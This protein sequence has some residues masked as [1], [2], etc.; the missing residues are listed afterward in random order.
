MSINSA[1]TAIYAE[2][3]ITPKMEAFLIKRIKSGQLTLAE[4]RS[5]RDLRRR[6]KRGEILLLSAQ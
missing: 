4:K 2:K 5:I 1:L 6:V 3:L